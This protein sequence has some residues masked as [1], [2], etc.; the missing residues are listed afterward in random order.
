MLPVD[1]PGFGT[2]GP[3]QRWLR[4]R[5]ELIGGVPLTP[6]VRAALVADI[7]SPLANFGE[8][9]LDYINA[10][11]TL[12]LARLPVGEWIGVEASHR[13]ADAGVS[14]AFCVLHDERGPIGSSTVCA[15][16][17]PR[18]TPPPSQS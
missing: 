17:N 4:D 9:G 5:R 2:T 1:G 14:V 6:F 11:L 10:D 12:H 8:G 18:M 16:R 3:R 13:V 7:A 15:V